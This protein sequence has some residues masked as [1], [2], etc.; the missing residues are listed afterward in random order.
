MKGIV[1]AMH[2]I[3]LNGQNRCFLLLLLFLFLFFF[4][5]EFSFEKAF[6]GVKEQQTIL[7]RQVPC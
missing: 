5:P 3:D 1:Q 7:R 2:K 4:L 6:K